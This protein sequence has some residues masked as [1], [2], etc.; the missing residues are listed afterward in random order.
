MDTPQTPSSPASPPPPKRED[1]A[2]QS[3]TAEPAR[4]PRDPA[5]DLGSGVAPR[6]HQLAVPGPGSAVPPVLPQAPPPGSPSPHAAAA[7][8][9]AARTSDLG[10]GV[11]PRSPADPHPPAATAPDAKAVRAFLEIQKTLMGAGLHALTS[12]STAFEKSIAGRSSYHDILDPNSG[13][14]IGYSHDYTF[15]GHSHPEIV[16]RNGR[17]TLNSLLERID[18]INGVIGATNAVR[19]MQISPPEGVR[20]MAVLSSAVPGAEWAVRNPELAKAAIE[21]VISLV[22]YLGQAVAIAEAIKGRNMFGDELSA[23]ER[24]FL[25]VLAIVPLARDLGAGLATAGP[26]ITDVARA[27]GMTE[28]QVSHVLTALGDQAPRKEILASA[29][30]AATLGKEVSPRQQKALL[31]FARELESVPR[32]PAGPGGA[33]LPPVTTIQAAN[34]AGDKLAAAADDAFR[35]A[36]E[37]TKPPVRAADLGK[38]GTAKSREAFRAELTRMIQPENHE[39]HFLLDP[40]TRELRTSTGRGIDQFVWMDNPELIEAGH[41]G[42]AKNLAGSPPRLL[43]MSAY[44]N[45][46]ISST[47][48]HPARGGA[49]M[50]ESGYVVEIGNAPV[51]ATAARDMVAK[52]L[53]KPE[54]LAEARRV[55][56]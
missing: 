4:P 5:S 49:A 23:G 37:S 12:E 15:A 29:V 48:E 9:R 55:A 35:Q 18:M 16:D 19:N 3:P 8:P 22:P 30:A 2:P 43:V 32:S 13:Q 17:V 28:A 47:V 40:A 1:Q 10:S 52:G 27:S 46:Y 38:I 44:E 41:D 7:G 33:D 26:L 6:G 14:V 20:Q 21:T 31:D 39:L 56:F 53:L 54:L 24:A 51:S 36:V 42:S 25:G 50:L 45:R 11:A 34:I